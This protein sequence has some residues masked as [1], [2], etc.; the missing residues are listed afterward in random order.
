MVKRVLP[1]LLA[2]AV[3]GA[4]ATLEFCQLSCAQA[5]A[6]QSASRHA[7]S[8]AHPCHHH[9]EGQGVRAGQSPRACEHGG[10]HAVARSLAAVRGA[11]LTVPLALVAPTPVA[12]PPAARTP[13]LERDRRSEARD[14]SPASVPL[15]I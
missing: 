1:L 12:A 15:R 14:S 9:V 5:A 13:L 7:A 2:L 10:D 8:Q 4:P 6:V 11:S 3:A